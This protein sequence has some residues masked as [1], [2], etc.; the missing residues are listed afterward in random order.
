MPALEFA[1]LTA[2]EQLT[3]RLADVYSRSGQLH[4]MYAWAD[5][6][7]GHA[8][9]WS[10][11]PLDRVKRALIGVGFLGSEP[12]VLREL[13]RRGKLRIARSPDGT[14]HPKLLI[15][16]RG[17][18]GCAI[19][20]SSNFT[21]GGFERNTELNAFIAG[22][23]PRLREQR[24]PRR[25]VSVHLSG[26]EQQPIRGHHERLRIPDPLIWIQ[27]QQ[28][29]RP[30]LAANLGLRR[31]LKRLRDDI[32]RA[33]DYQEDHH[34]GCASHSA[35]GNPRIRT[36]PPQCGAQLIPPAHVE[37]VEDPPVG[38]RGL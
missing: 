17:D 30:Q 33:P 27:C 5:S 14:F 22:P 32:L 19:F 26:D 13:H 20:G 2:P 15:G 31:R 8:T 12:R 28:P 10:T 18:Q 37:A 23:L 21:T 4:L 6:N 34:K 16:T 7:A 25:C 9:H 36:R 35:E 1:L 24:D 29:N 3:K 11:L 38:D